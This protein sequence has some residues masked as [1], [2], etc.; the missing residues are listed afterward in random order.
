MQSMSLKSFGRVIALAALAMVSLPAAAEL[1]IGVVRQQAIF[2]KP[3]QD[4][5]S[6]LRS[7]FTKRKND[8]EASSEK[9]QDDVRNFQRDGD[10]MTQE[11]R[12][13]MEKDLKTRKMDLSDQAQQMDQDYETRQRQ[14]TMDIN[15]KVNSALQQV[16]KEKG[17]D[18]IVADP[19][20]VSA[21]VTD[22]TA[23]V[24]KKLSSA[25]AAAAPAGK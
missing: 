10:T 5:Q 12:A 16:A 14:L 8:L 19:A 17:Y 22:L 3:A 18:L 15:T 23:D 9:Y 2:E 1:K 7:E 24:V 6:M 21:N 11:Q 4:A 20:F 13:R 25:P